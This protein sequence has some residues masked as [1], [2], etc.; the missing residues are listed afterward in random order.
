MDQQTL[1]IDAVA[2]A[3]A[4]QGDQER[5]T[6][7]PYAGHL[8]EVAA[9]LLGDGAPAEVVA[10]GVLHDTVEDTAATLEDL[11]ECFGAGR[12][13]VARYSTPGGTRGPGR[14]ARRRTSRGCPRSRTGGCCG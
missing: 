10:A 11:R 13:V 8:F 2:Y 5:K 3:M 4:A 1:V 7:G 9:L 6:G 12:V 14:S